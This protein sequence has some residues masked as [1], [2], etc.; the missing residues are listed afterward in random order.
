MKKKLLA[1]G[2]VLCLSLGL[3]GCRL[4]LPEGEAAE[5]DKLIG[6]FVTT[7]HLDTFTLN[8][9]PGGK[10]ESGHEPIYAELCK[11]SY[12]NDYGETVT[13]ANYRFTELEGIS[14]FML[15]ITEENG[16]SYNTTQIDEAVQEVD[17]E[18]K[19]VNSDKQLNS[20]AG[21]LYVPEGTYITFY[22]NP[23]YQKADGSVYLTGGQG[24]QADGGSAGLTL[25]ET[26]KAVIA[27]E[28]VEYGFSV[29]LWVKERPLT[30]RV[31]LV[32]FGADNEV[33][34]IS[35]FL[36][37]ELPES[38]ESAE[39]VQCIVQENYYTDGE[40]EQQAERSVLSPESENYVEI[41]VPGD[42]GYL[43]PQRCEIVWR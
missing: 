4:A 9:G 7:K 28:S 22:L 40:A 18:L 1:L 39:G 26:T 23:V 10:L 25:S 27:G 19:T 6:A 21:S 36:P 17:R 32:E 41:L 31:R 11:E 29:E 38:F 14:C 33:L 5:R 3:C 15:Y 20:L 34:R 8:V 24:L 12:E 16:E 2:L 13:T 30:E 35:E 43:V 37:G 42:M